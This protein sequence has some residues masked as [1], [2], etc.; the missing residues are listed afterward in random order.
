MLQNLKPL[1][2]LLV[3]SNPARLFKSSFDFIREF[4]GL[5]E[6]AQGFSNHVNVRVTLVP[7]RDSRKGLFRE[8]LRITNRVSSVETDSKQ[9]QTFDNKPQFLLFYM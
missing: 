3:K 1:I 6:T 7:V 4:F 8:R 9:N 2:Y 5:F